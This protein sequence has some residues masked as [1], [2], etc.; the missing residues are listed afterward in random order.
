MVRQL[1]GAVVPVIGH[2][3]LM[4]GDGQVAQ[5]KA[6]T[7]ALRRH[8]G[9]HLRL[10]GPIIARPTASIPVSRGDPPRRTAG[11]RAVI[12]DRE[13]RASSRHGTVAGGPSSA[14]LTERLTTPN[15]Y[16][17]QP[18]PGTRICMTARL[19]SAQN[20]SQPWRQAAS[21]TGVQHGWTDLLAAL[22]YEDA[23]TDG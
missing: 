1:P 10:H 20:L 8:R 11:A 12:A 6:R 9:R 22:C 14:L 13:R 23:R 3:R 19:P 5:P 7:D 21:C 4:R 17:R 18:A 16:P 2:T 15:D